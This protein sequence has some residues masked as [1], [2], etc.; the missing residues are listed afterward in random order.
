MNERKRKKHAFVL[1]LCLVSFFSFPLCSSMLAVFLVLFCFVG[2][3]VRDRSES[4]PQKKKKV[5]LKK[6][7]LWNELTKIKACFLFAP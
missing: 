5:K 4:T 2:N 6:Q 7:A 3:E 1:L